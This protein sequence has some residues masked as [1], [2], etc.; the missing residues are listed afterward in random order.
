MQLDGGSKF[1]SPDDGDDL[2]YPML[3]E[4]ND[5]V[6]HYCVHKKLKYVS[7]VGFAGK[8]LETDFVKHLITQACNME[9]I[10]IVCKSSKKEAAFLVSL[11]HQIA[12]V[13]LS[14]I[15][16]IAAKNSPPIELSELL[17]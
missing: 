16:K 2:P 4:R 1:K 3:W 6:C 12:S 17:N 8:E 11:Q 15:V 10:T 9:K 5:D 13:N 7:I 14:I